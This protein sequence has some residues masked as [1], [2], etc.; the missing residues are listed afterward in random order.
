[1]RLVITTLNLSNFASNGPLPDDHIP[2]NVSFRA[3]ELAPFAS[4][5]QFQR[6]FPF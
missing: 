2:K 5:I 6:E 4:N 1:V 3:S